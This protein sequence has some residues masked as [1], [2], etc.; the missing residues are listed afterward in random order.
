MVHIEYAAAVENDILEEFER[1]FSAI[2]CPVERH[3]R[4]PNTYNAIEWALPA[5]LALW[6]SKAFFDGFLKELGK[7]SAS[8][9]KKLISAAYHRLRDKPNR[10]YAA[11]DLRQMADGAAPDSVGRPCPVLKFQL[12]VT[13]IS[14]SHTRCLSWVFPSGLSERQ[15]Q[16]AMESLTACLPKITSEQARH[17]ENLH[18]NACPLAYVYVP[19]RGWVTDLQ[20]INEKMTKAP[21]KTRKRKSKDA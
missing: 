17:L 5:V 6:I 13:S 11:A 2:R 15:M 14:S 9:F 20:L 1:Y 12:D 10:A 18:S 7:D 16:E 4:E 8:Q 21:K 3:V 19:S